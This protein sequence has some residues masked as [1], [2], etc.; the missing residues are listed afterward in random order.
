FVLSLFYHWRW[1]RWLC[2]SVRGVHELFWALIFLQVFGLHPLTGVLAILIPY[3]GICA[4]VY[5]ELLEET[6]DLPERYLHHVDRISR[7]TWAR[8]TQAWPHIRAY[9]GYRMECGLR[10]SAV[11]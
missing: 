8:V 3:T 5:A 1:V 7:F 10:S 4:R 9:S 6:S 11:L 2:A